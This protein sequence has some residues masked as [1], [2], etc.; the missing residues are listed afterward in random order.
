MNGGTIA[1]FDLDGTITRRETYI[2]YLIG[3]LARHPGRLARAAPL[4]GA[5]GLYAA[6]QRDNRW[7][8]TTFLRT[9]LGGLELRALE[10]WTEFFLDRL[11]ERGLRPRALEVIEQHRA[12]GDR[13]LL[14]TA[15]L[16]FYA[17][18]LGRRLGFD[19]VL[20]TRAAVDGT[21]RLTGELEGGNCY[22]AKKLRRVQD[23]LRDGA[24]GPPAT[25]YTD[26]QADLPLLQ[27]VERPIVVSPTRRMRRTATRL[28]IAI[29][30][31]G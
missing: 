4:A 7:L 19:E 12:A 9:I 29:E 6:G 8:K 14:V 5:L 21:G 24:P 15:S 16:S 27:F 28:G 3:F 13:I 30:D 17:E 18:P 2:A 1:L 23:Y 20:C 25:F 10:A 26:H 11:L 22:G 31:W